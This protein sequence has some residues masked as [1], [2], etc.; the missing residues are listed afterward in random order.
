MNA[1]GTGRHGITGGPRRCS[2]PPVRASVC[3]RVVLLAALA[4]GLAAF[5]ASFVA[6]DGPVAARGD[7]GASLVRLTLAWRLGGR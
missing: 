4:G 3:A 1:P 2:D 5:A 7:G 6:G